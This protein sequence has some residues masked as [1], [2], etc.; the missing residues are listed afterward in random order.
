MELRGFLGLT[1]YYR[2]F[3]WD[4]G[5]ITRPL[6]SMTKKGSFEWTEEGEKAFDKLKLA[7]TTM[8]V[9]ALPNFEKPFEVN[10]D[11]SDV[12]IGTVLVQSRRPDSLLEQGAGVRKVEWFVYIEKMM[13]VVEAVR[14]WR[15]Y[16]LGCKFI[17]VTDQQPLRHLLEQRIANPE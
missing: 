2:K 4:Y 13:A 12:G 17:I 10:I 16:L 14:L 5:T 3:V 9:L 8:P 6:T 1:G 7:M 11:A 15:P